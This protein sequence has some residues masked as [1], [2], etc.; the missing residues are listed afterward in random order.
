[1]RKYTWVLMPPVVVFALSML[2]AGCAAAPTA[3]VVNNPVTVEVTVPV[4]QTV[5]ATKEVPKE[6][7]VTATP[8]PPPPT[9]EGGK[10]IIR[11]GTGDSGEG[12]TP[13]QEIISRFE[14]DNPDILVQLEA[15][16]GSDYYTRLLTQIAARRP[17]D[18]MQI[19]DDAVPMFVDKGSFISLDDCLKTEPALDLLTCR[20]AGSRRWN[21]V[22]C[23]RTTRRRGTTTRR[24][25][26]SSK[27]P[28]RRTAGLGTIC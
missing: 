15:V 8:E 2:M 3:Q 19:G 10:T 28:T 16:A 13:H 20:G 1:M 23:R 6:I 11:V 25:S 4:L 12:L 7:V 5:V 18:I 14:Q 22:A 21:A 24:F 26:I 9:P 17:P 27:C